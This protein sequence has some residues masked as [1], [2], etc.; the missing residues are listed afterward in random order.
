MEV[1]CTIQVFI[2]KHHQQGKL[3]FHYIKYC[4]VKKFCRYLICAKYTKSGCRARAVLP[5]DHPIESLRITHEHNHPPDLLAQERC[6]FLNDLKSTVKT[7]K[8]SLK[9]CFDSVI[10][11]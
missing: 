1:L 7:S 5:V 6:N 11:M 9:D 4:L 10:A 3:N 8:S 2:R